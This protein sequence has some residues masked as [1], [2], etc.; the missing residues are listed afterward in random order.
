MN[1]ASLVS[2]AVFVDK[3]ASLRIR[4]GTAAQI[5]T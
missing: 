2:V 1:T 5:L 4:V 3:H